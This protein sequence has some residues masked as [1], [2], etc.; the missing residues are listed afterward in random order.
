[1]S[2]LPHGFAD[3]EGN[4]I[5]APFADQFPLEMLTTVLFAEEGEGTRIEVSWTP[6]EATPE[7]EDFF[8]SMME[9]FKGGWS[10]S[11]E[12]LDAFL[13]GEA[14]GLILPRTGEGFHAGAQFR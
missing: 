10:G 13:A 3:A 11:F 14:R 8:A 6:L 9:S 5:L 2:G 1:M 12:Q 4:R 7:E